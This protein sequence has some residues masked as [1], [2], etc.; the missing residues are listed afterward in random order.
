M[1]NIEAMLCAYIEGD[2][3]TAGRAQIEKHLQ[4]NPQHRKLIQE[5]IAM[6]D[7]VRGLPRVKA[8]LDVGESLRGKVERSILLD[9]SPEAGRER[10]GG[11]RWPQI[12]AVAAIFLLCA[13]LCLILYRA[14]GPT[15]RPPV[16][17]ENVP[18]KLSPTFATPPIDSAAQPSI[19][20]KQE[21]V[22]AG[23]AR[24]DD[25]KAVAAPPPM[26]AP[27]SLAI[28]QHPSLVSQ[29]QQQIVTLAQLNN[30]EA[31]RRRLQNSGYDIANATA[32][33]APPVLMVVDST[34]PPATNAQVTQF[35]S[36]S[37]GISWK[38]VPADTQANSIPT[39]LPSVNS[40]QQM[41]STIAPR[42]AGEISASAVPTTQPASDVYIATGFTS[43]QADALRQSLAVQQ[44]L[45]KVQVSLQSAEVLATTQPSAQP[46]DK[47]QSGAVRAGAASPPATEPS[48]AAN[49]SAD[50]AVPTTSPSN[51]S[52]GQLSP[53]VLMDK[54]SSVLANSP[55]EVNNS[56][57]SP[58]GSKILQPV[59]AVIVVQ[60]TAASAPAPAISIT[61]ATQPSP[62][63]QP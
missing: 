21:T 25:R 52:P 22:T 32:N 18:P 30:V 11:S 43:Q 58:D 33:A 3:D 37:N 45:A 9:D 29:A 53:A 23:G 19:P 44:N 34:D 60:A 20:T 50:L 54:N 8:P 41:L 7:L 17:T 1:E 35:L 38:R 4:E 55:V 16:F 61:P 12:F 57:A 14:L 15:L 36:N 42:K 46:Q 62:S 2:L 10:I 39:T 24:L 31:I 49:S 6:R 59:D 48:E 5:L 40:D 63:T 28:E 27:G 13:S 56:T 26:V 51:S 47:D